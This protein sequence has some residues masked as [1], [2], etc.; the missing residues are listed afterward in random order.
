MRPQRHLRILDRNTEG[1]FMATAIKVAFA[2]S[3]LKSVDQH[4]GAA[5]SFLMYGVDAAQIRLIEV[6]QFDPASMDGHEHK[7][8]GKIA[9][10][11]GCAVVYVNAIGASAVNQLKAVGIQP[12]KVRVGRRIDTLL[13]DL[14][15]ELRQGPSAWLARAIEQSK[16]RDP[17]RFAA[18]EA[19][20]WDEA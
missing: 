19:E 12:V 3:D 4:F 8:I 7:L 18:M 17:E 10:L 2:T 9:A 16:P 20:G 13:A 15:K 5:E 14:Q 6:A 1:S 11:A